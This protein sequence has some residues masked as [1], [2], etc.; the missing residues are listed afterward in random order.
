M[1]IFIDVDGTLVDIDDNPRPYIPDLIRGAAALSL[2]IVIW[3]AGGADYAKQKFLMSCRKFGINLDPHI[4][5]YMF[6]GD[7]EKL[8]L[9]DP[10]FYVDDVE[11]LLIAQKRKNPKNHGFKV[12]FYSS[13]QFFN[14]PADKTLLNALEALRLWHQN[15]TSAT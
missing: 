12:P 13:A 6:K 4:Y 1:W 7:G 2:N 3:S 8:I 5:G 9:K 11:A 14:K 15:V 10:A